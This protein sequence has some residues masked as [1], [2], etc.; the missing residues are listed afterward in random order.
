MLGDYAD[1]VPDPAGYEADYH[2]ALWHGV[3]LPLL[4]SA[5]GARRPA[6]RSISSRGRL[7]RAR[8]A[9]LPLGNADR[10][11]DAVLRGA[12]IMSVRLTAVTQRGSIPA[13]QSVILITLVLVSGWPC[14]RSG[15]ATGRSSRCGS[16]R[17]RWSSALL[18]LAA[19]LGADG[20]CATGWPRCCWSA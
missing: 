15:P 11:Y 8:L 12:D 3:N 17:R 16:P 18:M 20:A 9:F 10:I 6:S 7:R 13:T 19:A 2:L 1:T 5:A 4:L 14:W